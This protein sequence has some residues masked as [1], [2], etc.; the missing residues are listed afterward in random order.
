MSDICSE[1]CAISQDR[2][3]ADAGV[4]LPA[5]RV[6]RKRIAARTVGVHLSALPEELRDHVRI[7]DSEYLT[8]YDLPDSI[9]LT[10]SDG[11]VLEL[12]RDEA[13]K[14]ADEA[15][16]RLEWDILPDNL[17]G[18]LTAAFA[19]T[20][21]GIYANYG[22]PTMD[23]SGF[24]SDSVRAARHAG[25]NSLMLGPLFIA[26]DTASAIGFTALGHLT[27]KASLSNRIVLADVLSTGVYEGTSAWTSAKLGVFTGVR[28]IRLMTSLAVPGAHLAAVPVGFVVGAATAI[29]IKRNANKYKDKAIDSLQRR[30]VEKRYGASLMNQQAVA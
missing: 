12:T 26:M 6:I 20:G 21:Q 8:K 23:F 3:P 7:S 16:S 10:M 1:K 30:K 28:A 5:N 2:H 11:E 15:G 29:F 24:Y 9:K 4:A 17:A 13:W 18:K 27:R 19:E 14:L 22:R 25:G